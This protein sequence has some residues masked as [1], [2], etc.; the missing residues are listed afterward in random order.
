MCNFYH[1]KYS[2][3]PTSLR[4]GDGKAAYTNGLTIKEFQEKYNLR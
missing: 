3:N 4:V 1:E 2:S